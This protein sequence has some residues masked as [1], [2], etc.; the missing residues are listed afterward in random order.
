MKRFFMLTLIFTISI[1]GISGF[2]I[3]FI[4]SANL[5]VKAEDDTS[6]ICVIGESCKEA[7]PDIAVIT[8]S[9][10]TLGSSVNE[11]KELNDQT[12]NSAITELEALG[13]D[14]NSIVTHKFTALP[15]ID[16]PVSNEIIGYKAVNA[17]SF[18]IR[19]LDNIKTAVDNILNV[20]VTTIKHISYELSN[21]EELY[22]EALAEA[23]ENAK[24][25]ASSLATTDLEVISIKEEFVYTSSNIS[26]HH[27]EGLN[28][29]NL[30]KIVINA[31]LKV[32]FSAI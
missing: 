8:A 7:I 30:G 10:E 21:Q 2:L 20:G 5:N 18:E 25:K 29:L 12:F 27:A 15:C 11:A 23:L 14:N 16:W 19:N 6:T 4:P 32:E 9:I 26:Q 28:I 3:N 13:V 24:S 22:N 17:F 1:C 31:R